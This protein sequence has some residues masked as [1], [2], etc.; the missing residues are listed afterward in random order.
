MNSQERQAIIAVLKGARKP[1]SIPD[2]M[3]AA[4]RANRSATKALL[5]K[6]R[7]TGEVVSEKGLYSLP[8]VNAQQPVNAVNDQQSVNTADDAPD[9][10][11]TEPS[12]DQ[13]TEGPTA[14]PQV[15]PWA[16]SDAEVACRAERFRTARREK[17]EAIATRV[18]R[19]ELQDAGVPYQQLQREVDRIRQLAETCYIEG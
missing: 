6:M 11:A 12:V 3:A 4:G 15:E 17:G 13:I 14:R 5:H 9:L 10:G 2:I 8:A 18:L 19:W 1:M 7:M 16:L